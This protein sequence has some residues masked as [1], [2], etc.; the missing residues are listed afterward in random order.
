MNQFRTT[1]KMNEL[2]IGKERIE[3]TGF[4]TK[5]S[6]YICSTLCY[7]FIA[8][9]YGLNETCFV[10]CIAERER[11]REQWHLCKQNHFVISKSLRL[12]GNQQVSSCEREKFYF[13]V[14]IEIKL[15]SI[16]Y[17]LRNAFP[18]SFIVTVWIYRMTNGKMVKSRLNFSD[19][20]S[21]SSTGQFCAKAKADENWFQQTRS[22]ASHSQTIHRIKVSSMLRKWKIGHVCN[23]YWKIFTS[24]RVIYEHHIFSTSSFA[25]RALAPGRFWSFDLFLN[26]ICEFVGL[27][28][29]P[30][31]SSHPIK[32][33]NFHF[34]IFTICYLQWQLRLI[35]HVSNG[36][37]GK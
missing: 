32:N 3:W 9:K 26:V 35:F 14:T 4:E 16:V 22:A 11:E 18:P 13:W 24:V 33:H 21:H 2:Y 19:L 31:E 5:V 36:Y 37:G 12:G 8:S 27:M 10:E 6:S 7:E 20:W 23:S 25:A 15:L 29:Q 1:R 17:E 34:T 28:Q 30:L